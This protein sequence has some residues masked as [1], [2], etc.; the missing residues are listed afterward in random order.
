MTKPFRLHHAQPGLFRSAI[1]LL[2]LILPPPL[3]HAGTPDLGK[4]GIES[5]NLPDPS[6]EE[7]GRPPVLEVKIETSYNLGGE[8][9]YRGKEF[10]DS[11]AFNIN[12][13]LGTMMPLSER[14]MMSLELQS[15]NFLLNDLPGVPMP[16]AIHTLELGTGLAFRPNDRWMFM[17]RLNTSLYRLED[18]TSDDIGLGGGVMAMWQYSDSLKWV[19]GAMYQPDNDLPVIPLL[20]VDWL[21]NEH[22]QLQLAFPQPRLIYNPGGKWRLHAGMDLLLG[23]TFRTSDTLGSD[24]GLPKF[25]NE[26]GSYSDIRIGG[27]FGYQLSKSLSLEAEGG[28]S[29][30]REIEYPDLDQK[31]KFD[32]APYFR[33]GLKFA[34]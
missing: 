12:F 8:T 1:L 11:D 23:T 33:V 20:G 17:A 7:D 13:S 32:P 16:D 31:V 14:W 10:G 18:I 21:I 3:L 25:D 29:V 15:Q 34:F 27:G 22:W 19:F 9:E 26:L 2:P 6:P 24:M 5:V 28:F 30:S 4:S